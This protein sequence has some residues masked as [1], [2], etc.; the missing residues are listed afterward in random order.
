MAAPCCLVPTAVPTSGRRAE[1]PRVCACDDR[2]AVCGVT[3][4]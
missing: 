1:A 3:R 4:L 2:E